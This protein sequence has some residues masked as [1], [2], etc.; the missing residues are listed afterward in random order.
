LERLIINTACHTSPRGVITAADSVFVSI[1]IFIDATVSRLLCLD[2]GYGVTSPLAGLVGGRLFVSWEEWPL[3]ISSVSHRR[4]CSPKTVL[5]SLA[6]VSR[7]LLEGFRAAVFSSEAYSSSS[8]STSLSDPSI[9]LSL[10]HSSPPSLLSLTSSSLLS[11]PMAED[12]SLVAARLEELNCTARYSGWYVSSGDDNQILEKQK[13]DALQPALA[14]RLRIQVSAW[15]VLGYSNISTHPFPSSL[16]E[17]CPFLPFHVCGTFAYL[18]ST[19]LSLVPRPQG[20][21][22][23]NATFGPSYSQRLIFP[24]LPLAPA[25]WCYNR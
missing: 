16:Q 5:T 11:P 13:T 24:T 10:W 12:V 7:T 15:N 3:L 4:S 2:L 9:P 17:R 6:A 1:F 21:G 25:F 18:T 19:R 23:A 14:L 20:Y 22:P 8:S